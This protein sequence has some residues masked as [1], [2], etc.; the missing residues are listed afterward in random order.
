MS[1]GIRTLSI[2]S[3]LSR[4]RKSTAKQIKVQLEGEGIS[5]SERTVQRDLKTLLSYKQ[6]QLC[7][8]ESN[9][10]GWSIDKNAR[11]SLPDFDLTTSITFAMADKH[12]A[13]MLPPVMRERLEPYFK[14]AKQFL[15]DESKNIVSHWPEKIVVHTKGLPLHS[16]N[17]S[18]SIIEAV[19]SAA[20]KGKQLSISYHSLKTGKKSSFE[21]NPYGIVVRNERSYLI[22]TYE[23]YSDVRQLAISRIYEAEALYKSALIEPSFSLKNFVVKGEMGGSRNDEKLVIKLW[24]T[25]FLATILTETPLA[26]NQDIAPQGDDFIVTVSVD[27]TDELRHWILSMC[28]HI[29]VLSPIS[30]REEIKETLTNSLSYYKD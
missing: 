14:T 25:P 19:Y 13:S 11:L 20:L 21:F 4:Y 6:F 28:P 26:K 24:I 7:A 17:I 1:S 23:G 29:T 10:I 12:L 22:G 16:P 8:D 18:Q 27:D 2:I 5:V 9:P 3:K 15:R 30:L